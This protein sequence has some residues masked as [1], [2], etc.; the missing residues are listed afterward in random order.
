MR[1]L[2]KYISFAILIG[3]MAATSTF[4]Q[5]RAQSDRTTEQQVARQLRMLPYYGVFDHITFE[6]QGETVV[7]SGKVNS[8]GT[9][10]AAEA[11]M[12]D[13][14]GISNVVNQIEELPPSPYDARLRRAAFLTFNDRG[15]SR[16]LWEPNPEIRIIV[17]NGRI[18]IEGHVSNQSDSNLA[19][20]LANSIPGVFEV[21]NNLIV[22]RPVPR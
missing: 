14:S 17:Q 20:L 22:G 12:K 15:L 4:A 16:Y 13:V 7:L 1:T 9:R 2:N 3:L 5:M 10:R 11:A 19:N 21:T 8:L 18:T 6:L